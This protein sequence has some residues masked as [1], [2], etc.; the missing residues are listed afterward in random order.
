[1]NYVNGYA[2]NQNILV[3]MIDPSFLE[4]HLKYTIAHE[5]N[6]VVAMENN[7]AYTLL[8][9]TILEGKADTFAKMIIQPW[10]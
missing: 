2:W 8:E 5:Y 1:M 7:E 9:G 6:H 3:I 4:E 10:I